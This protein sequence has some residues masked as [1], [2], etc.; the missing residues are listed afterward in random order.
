MST[1]PCDQ[2]GTIECGEK[3][4]NTYSLVAGRHSGFIKEDGRYAEDWDDMVNNRFYRTDYHQFHQL[5][6][7][8]AITK[9][10]SDCLKKLLT[11]LFPAPMHLHAEGPLH[12]K[13]F[14]F[15]NPNKFV[16]HEQSMDALFPLKDEYFMAGAPKTDK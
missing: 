2:C 11:D 5:L 8:E 1:R 15:N 3:V 16:F 6:N 14:L 13:H 9:P 4:K 10:P 7:N 12:P